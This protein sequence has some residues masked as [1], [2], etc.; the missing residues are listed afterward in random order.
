MD[1]SP[2]LKPE[3]L[4]RDKFLAGLAPFIGPQNWHEDFRGREQ[5]KSLE[6]N[7]IALVSL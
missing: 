6:T 1:S 2:R 5:N 3:A 4:R 7:Y